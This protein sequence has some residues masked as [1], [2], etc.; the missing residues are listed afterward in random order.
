MSITAFSFPT[1]TLFGPGA[2]SELA[3]RAKPLG[4]HKPLVVT[5]P[6]LVNTAAFEALVKVLGPAERDKQW[7]VFSGVYPNPLENDV[8][9]AAAAFR[10]HNCDSIIGFGG[11]SPLDVG[12]APR[13]LVRPPRREFARFYDESDWGGLAPF[14]AIPTTA[15]TGS[16]VGR[17]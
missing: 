15:G 8:R 5:D 11:G 9:E 16:E 4:L 14:V 17:S 7:F 1:R 12:Q 2:I 13:L 3:V 6:G 10:R